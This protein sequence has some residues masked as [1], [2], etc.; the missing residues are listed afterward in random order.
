MVFY[1]YEDV[2]VVFLLTECTFL[3]YFLPL[4]NVFRSRGADVVL[5][6]TR[7]A[8]HSSPHLFLERI[9]VIAQEH[10]LEIAE[11]KDVKHADF[12]IT[13]EGSGLSLLPERTR[14][15]RVVVITYMI[16]F[17]SL[18]E[19]YS[20]FADLIVFP[21][22][23]LPTLFGKLDG[24]N[25]YGGSPKYDVILDS[26]A[27]RERLQIDQEK[28]IMTVLFPKAR[29][30]AA[31]NLEIVYQALRDAGFFIVVKSRTKDSAPEGWQRGDLYVEDNLWYPHETMELLSISEIV[32]QFGSTAIKEALMLDVKSINIDIKPSNH[33]FEMHNVLGCSK[34]VR[35]HETFVTA[36][37]E[38]LITPT[39]TGAFAFARERFLYNP[40]EGSSCSEGLAD[41][42]MSL[43]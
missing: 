16:D 37:E 33:L 32:V 25:W 12:V 41:E 10:D 39:S 26:K 18:Y 42:I 22:R 28:K 29:D 43:P 40:S 34:N 14:G 17:V 13:V 23:Y 36:L 24:R 6:I 30:L 20:A 27:I 15:S 31:A 8:K 5:A 7:T 35:T 9:K 3:R 38:L 11:I 4:A 2:R 21:G 1:G 19:N